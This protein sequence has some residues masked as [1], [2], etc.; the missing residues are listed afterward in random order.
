MSK[1]TTIRLPDGIQKELIDIIKVEQKI[2]DEIL[3]LN[4]MK[5]VKV[6]QSAVIIKSIIHYYEYL[7]EEGY[8]NE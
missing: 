4:N 6:T 1:V 3:E 8:I 5:K 7:K 2:L